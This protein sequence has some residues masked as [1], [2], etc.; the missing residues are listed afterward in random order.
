M[1][2]SEALDRVQY[3]DDLPLIRQC[4]TCKEW[5]DEQSEVIAEA[6]GK[7][8]YV[9]SHGMCVKCYDEFDAQFEDDPVP[10]TERSPTYDCDSLPTD[11]PPEAA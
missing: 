7:I 4:A 10:E 8:E 5:L 11:P 9:I 3:V 6:R 2:I 1:K